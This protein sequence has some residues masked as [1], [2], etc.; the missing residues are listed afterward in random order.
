MFDAV[1]GLYSGKSTD[2]TGEQHIVLP[3]IKCQLCFVG[4]IH[5]WV[6]YCGFGILVLTCDLRESNYMTQF[7]VRGLVAERAQQISWRSFHYCC[8]YETLFLVFFSRFSWKQMQ[9][10]NLI[11]VFACSTETETR[12]KTGIDLSHW[13]VACSAAFPSFIR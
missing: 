6:P 1:N 9:P 12:I 11:F 8:W 13:A 5:F 10:H 3:E 7:I 4:S 2:T